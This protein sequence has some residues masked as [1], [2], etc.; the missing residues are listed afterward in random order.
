MDANAD[1]DGGLERPSTGGRSQSV[2]AAL[3]E[4]FRLKRE[5]GGS[6]SKSGGKGKAADHDTEG[7]ETA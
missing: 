4:F 7:D 3:G 2:G 5:R 1:A 6:G